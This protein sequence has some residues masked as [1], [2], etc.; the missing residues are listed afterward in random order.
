MNPPYPEIETEHRIFRITHEW[1][2]PDSLQFTLLTAVAAI[3]GIER[4]DLPRLDDSIDM[5]ALEMLFATAGS[6]GTPTDHISFVYADYLV[7]VLR[8]GHIILQPIS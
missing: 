7:D 3:K 5:D 6:G 2:G 8:N 1:N 4:T